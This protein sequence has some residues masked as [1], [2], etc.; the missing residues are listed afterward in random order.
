MRHERKGEFISELVLEMGI[1]QLEK[2]L[3]LVRFLVSVEKFS[4]QFECDDKFSEVYENE[5]FTTCNA[6]N[7]AYEQL[8]KG[9]LLSQ[10]QL[11][12][13]AKEITERVLIKALE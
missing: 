13:L 6:L 3:E 12:R 7:D 11:H 9:C 5:I 8:M 4:A 10:P 2:P 1:I